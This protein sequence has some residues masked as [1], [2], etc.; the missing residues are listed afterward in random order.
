MSADV[1]G[2]METHAYRSDSEHSDA[3]EDLE[4]DPR[5]SENKKMK[6]K[7]EEVQG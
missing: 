3:D 1:A 7:L 4:T 2:P 5:L 6:N